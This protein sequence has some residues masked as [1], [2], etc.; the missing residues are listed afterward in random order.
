M[1]EAMFNWIFFFF[2]T[3]FMSSYFWKCAILK[4]I[5]F[6]VK[7]R[8]F[9]SYLCCN[10]VFGELYK[11]TYKYFTILC[12]QFPI[13]FCHFLGHFSFVLHMYYQSESFYLNIYL[14]TLFKCQPLER[15]LVSLWIRLLKQSHLIRLIIIYWFLIGTAR[16]MNTCDLYYLLMF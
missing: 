5:I 14:Y 9:T 12:T 10:F 1:E 16:F 8:K 2:C 11:A 15:M 4:N 13:P 3:R 7:P 6:T